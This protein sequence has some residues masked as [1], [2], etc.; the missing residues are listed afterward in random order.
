MS[1]Y[2]NV[3][4]GIS[5]EAGTLS[6]G[7]EQL[8][9]V[10]KKPG[11]QTITIAADEIKN[12]E[13]LHIDK[14]K[15]LMRISFKEKSKEMV[16]FIGFDGV[17]FDAMDAVC[18]STVGKG[19]AAKEVALSGQ[20]WG[21]FGLK[22][23]D[24][25]CRTEEKHVLFMVPYHTMSQSV[26]QSRNEISIEFK[27]Q[28]G[29]KENRTPNVVAGDQLC[30]I[31]MFIP[32]DEDGAAYREFHE[33]LKKK[34]NLSDDDNDL[35]ARFPRVVFRVPR[36][37]KDMLFYSKHFKFRTDTFE[38]RIRYEQIRKLFVFEQPGPTVSFV[39]E[40]AQG[41]RQGLQTYCHLVMQFDDDEK[42]KLEVKATE[43]QMQ[44]EY[45]SKD[46]K[47]VLHRDML[48]PTY[49][50]M[51]R[52]FMAL[53]KIKIIAALHFK[54]AEGD[55]CVAC[56]HG[57]S[58][59]LLYPLKK[60]LFFI[61]KPVLHIRHSDVTKVE[62]LR[63]DHNVKAIDLA[64][65]Q[66]GARTLFT[67]IDRKEY[68]QLIRYFM[69][70]LPSAVHDLKGHEA[71]LNNAMQSSSRSTRTRKNIKPAAGSSVGAMDDDEDED[72]D[73]YNMDDDAAMLDEDE[74][75]DADYEQITE[76]MDGDED[77]D[78]EVGRKTKGKKRK[79]PTKEMDDDDAMIA[80]DD[81]DIDME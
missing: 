41:I 67:G 19:L 33:T 45:A 16:R 13:W 4:L 18:K 54:S 28:R 14:T 17:A 5:H 6:I 75:H 31:R 9:W 64:I 81:D 24:M 36:G 15:K 65:H 10:E 34:A 56:S 77:C 73:D 3:R 12:I 50:V 53:S 68:E 55:R 40:L 46:G 21:R 52:V 63:M 79:A 7:R 20:S 35:I 57:A 69:E 49:E 8:Q 1:S 72:D 51:S 61:H 38:Y 47:R 25:V 23:H 37:N 26:V 70:K 58:Q 59:G 30:E 27:P 76:N 32:D 42:T 39:V 43:Q 66:R 74:D 44:N 60:S 29:G 2:N 11:S 48:G 78:L 22:S 71:R 62:M 80:T